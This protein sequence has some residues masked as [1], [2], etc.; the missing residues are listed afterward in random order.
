MINVRHQ[1]VEAQR[2]G[3]SR[4]PPIELDVHP[5]RLESADVAVEDLR[6]DVAGDA[7]AGGNL[8]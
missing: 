7:I 4:E 5:C 3:A 6:K 8:Q 2:A 1:R